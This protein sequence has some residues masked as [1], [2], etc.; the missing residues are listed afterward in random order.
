M[1][2]TLLIAALLMAFAAPAQAKV[3]VKLAT[4]APEGTSW[5]KA[6]RQI[7]DEWSRISG[8]EVEVKI[9]AGGVVGNES[10]MVRKMRIGQVHGGQITNVGLADFDHAAQVIQTPLLIH[11]NA[12][13]DHVMAKMTPVFEERLREK[14][15]VVLNWGDAGWVHFFTGEPMKTPADA[16]KFKMYAYEGDPAAVK[17]FDSFGFNSVVMTATDVLPSLQSGLID[18][19]PATRLGGLSLQWFAL[20]K[21]MLDVPWAPL[22]GAT[23]I[24]TDVWAAIPEQYHAEFMKAARQV[25]SDMGQ[26]IRR[27]DVKAVSVMEKYGLTVH[28]VDDATRAA[29]NKLGEATWPIVRSE[30]VPPDV[31]DA[32]VQHLQEFRA[33]P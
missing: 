25:G 14:G 28:Q 4:L 16:P 15:V 22:V 29:W 2:R 24:S 1:M 19:F 11:D 23:V 32:V 9:Y 27:Q 5:F 33:Q 6:L 7:G 26:T 21:N 17:L 8:G 10:Q 20:A 3:T 30:M 12:E 13:L 31:F 18:A